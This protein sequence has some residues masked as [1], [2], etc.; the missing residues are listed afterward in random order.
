M[1]TAQS[2]TKQVHDEL[3]G[4]L[5]DLFGDSVQVVDSPDPSNGRVR[6]GY[7]DADL[8]CEAGVVPLNTSCASISVT[9]RL[10]RVFVG[11]RKALRWLTNNRAGNTV[12]LLAHD[13]AFAQREL[14]LY[15]NRVT[16]PGD[17][18]GAKEMLVDIHFELERVAAGLRYWFPQML[19]GE[20]LAAFEKLGRQDGSQ[21]LLNIISNPQGFLNWLRDNPEEEAQVNPSLVWQAL[22]WLKRWDEQLPWLD[23]DWARL[24]E[25]DRTPKARVNW[26]TLRA[27]A[28]AEL[29]RS[30]ELLVVAR[31]LQELLKD[32]DSAVG[33]S[34]AAAALY[35]LGRY[36]EVME[37]LQGAT[38]D[39][40]PRAWYWRS[41]A[42]A[43]LGNKEQSLK[44]YGSY[45]QG[46]GGRDI[47]G[48]QKLG[49]VLPKSEESAE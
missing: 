34:F 16:L 48:R 6:Y 30:E 41:L 28:L 29:K 8:Q 47:L 15:C 13:D 45:E 14:W 36:D 1:S 18:A 20:D 44:L 39:D 9:V 49:E 27:V 40:N 2:A 11:Y 26:L 37:E 25:A 33:G 22:G 3:V 32:A 23:R 38:F 10:G 24:A 43:Q 21:A 46:I 4:V 42:A 7:D 5:A 31:Q 17:S 12:G 35:L 19:S